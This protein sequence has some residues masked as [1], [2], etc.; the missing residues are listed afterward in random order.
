MLKIDELVS[1]E[2]ILLA[3]GRK[4]GARLCTAKIL[5]LGKLITKCKF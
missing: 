1:K 2:D 5:P 4:T 3:T